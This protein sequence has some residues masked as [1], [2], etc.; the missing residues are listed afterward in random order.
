[1][2]MVREPDWMLGALVRISVTNN[3]MFRTP[4]D[5][6]VA[7]VIEAPKIETARPTV[8]VMYHDGRIDTWHQSDLQVI[9]KREV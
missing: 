9:G 4:Y 6:T 7:L 3:Y 1:M 2:S 8:R 5:G